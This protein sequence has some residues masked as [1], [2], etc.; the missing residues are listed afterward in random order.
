MKPAVFLDRDGTIIEDKGH[1]RSINDV[2][3]YSNTVW[4]LK[5]L[6]SNFELFIVTH[7]PGISRGL[8][9]MNDVKN[10]N[11]V[12]AGIDPVAVDSL[13]ATLFGTEGKN[14][15]YIQRAHEM[16][17]GEIDLK[18]LKIETVNLAT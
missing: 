9:T 5:Q 15:G 16:G 7:Q 12:I 18:K 6:N 1:L 2:Q 3:I 4:S 8:L 10:I 17:L 11:T 13:G 14:L